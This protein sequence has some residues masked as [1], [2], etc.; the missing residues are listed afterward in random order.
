MSERRV[1][2]PGVDSPGRDALADE[3]RRALDEAMRY[4]D[5]DWV[6][7]AD[8]ALAW[9]AER[10]AGDD[11]EHHRAD[12]HDEPGDAEPHSDLAT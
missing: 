5:D 12:G 9:F 8:A 4:D 7:L 3:M 2:L 10:L 1:P 11:D 6:R